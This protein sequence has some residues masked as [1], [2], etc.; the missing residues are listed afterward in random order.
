[1]L[2]VPATKK[3]LV[4]F[5]WCVSSNFPHL[6]NLFLVVCF[7]SKSLFFP[8]RFTLSQ[9]VRS[10]FVKD[11]V[12]WRK[13]LIHFVFCRPLSTIACSDAMYKSYITEWRMDKRRGTSYYCWRQFLRWI[14][15]GV[16][17]DVGVERSEF[18]FFP[19]LFNL[20]FILVTH[21]ETL[22]F[23]VFFIV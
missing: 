21:F 14:T 10:I 1:M 3:K 6:N 7:H 23:H 16:W 4:D 20:N 11:N 17:N 9:P 15:S 22:N 13:I 5:C 19:F 12:N 18:P 2:F 8:F